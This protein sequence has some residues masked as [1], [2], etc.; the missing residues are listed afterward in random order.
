[1]PNRWSTVSLHDCVG[2]DADPVSFALDAKTA[3]ILKRLSLTPAVE[4]LLLDDR[5]RIDVDCARHI[6]AHGHAKRIALDP[7]RVLSFTTKNGAS[8]ST[9][10]E[11]LVNRS[12]DVQRFVP[13]DHNARP[14]LP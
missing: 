14:L 13:V 3:A 6:T 8:S 1:M 12:A 10:C 11:S 5:L 7:R 9:G 4:H 2:V